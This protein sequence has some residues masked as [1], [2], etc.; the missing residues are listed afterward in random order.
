MGEQFFWFY[1]VVVVGIFLICIYLY[2]KKGFL[3]SV[4]LLV[5]RIAA[6]VIA[7][8]LSGA[9]ASSI[10]TNTMEPK[11]TQEISSR[12][13]VA[14]D[15]ANVRDLITD[16]TKT[17]PKAFQEAMLSLADI[18]DEAMDKI[19][20]SLDKSSDDIAKAISQ[21]IIRPIIE[22]LVRIVLFAI[23]FAVL[24]IGVNLVA[25]MFGTLYNIP[26]IGQLN[27]LLGGVLGLINAVVILFLLVLTLK[28]VIIATG[29]DL[30]VINEQTIGNSTIFD[31]IYNFNFPMI[32]A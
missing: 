8:L 6:I 30:I 2:A 22:F 27:M 5:G 21:E 20:K 23:F 28:G 9:I 11:I 13:D 25:K 14:T 15:N 3:R 17:F 10:Y 32:P 26:I 31:W 16:A 12:I 24:M 4:V 18:N 19:D 29:N 7:I 1:D